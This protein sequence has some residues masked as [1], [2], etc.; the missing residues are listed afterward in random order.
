MFKLTGILLFIFFLNGDSIV[1]QVRVQCFEV[2]SLKRADFFID[3]LKKEPSAEAKG[4]MATMLFLKSRIYKFPFKKMSFF[5]RG[6]TLLEE[7]IDENPSNLELRYLRYSIQNKAPDFLGYNNWV[8]QD[9]EFIK[10]NIDQIQISNNI[11]VIILKN[12][13]LYNDVNL[14]DKVI[15]EKI[16][17]KL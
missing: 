7:S 13:L 8:M 14:Q 1:D 16:L 17:D 5:N 4:Y 9:L 11:K 10:N 2:D 12:I 15:F 6:K 3:Q